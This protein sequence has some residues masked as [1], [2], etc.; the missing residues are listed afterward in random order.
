MEGL[1]R[2]VEKQGE[3]A[4]KLQ[5]E[6]A[7]AGK[8]GEEKPPEESPKDTKEETSDQAPKKTEEPKKEV[9]AKE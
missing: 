6:I 5:K 1:P 9:K 4:E 7:E 2:N 3:E 8:T